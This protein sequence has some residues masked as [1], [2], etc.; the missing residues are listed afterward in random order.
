[1]EAETTE[2]TRVVLTGRGE[3]GAAR[4]EAALS[5]AASIAVHLARAGAGVELTG[6]G[7]FVP[8]GRGPGQARRILT[9]LA[10]YDPRAHAAGAAEFGPGGSGWRSLREVRVELD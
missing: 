3:R 8:L 9:E 7:L 5:E 6:A 4:L 2:D 10:L 1:M